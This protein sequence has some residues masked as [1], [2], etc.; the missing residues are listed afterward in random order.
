ME[1]DLIHASLPRVTISD[2]PVS[3]MVHDVVPLDVLWPIPLLFDQSGGINT[4]L[5]QLNNALQHTT[6]AVQNNNMSFAKQGLQHMKQQPNCL[7]KIVVF[8]NDLGW[9]ILPLNQLHL[10][11]NA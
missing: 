9:S 5:L 11:E 3:E 10:I 4:S 1:V 6:P 2:F 7:S 8:Q